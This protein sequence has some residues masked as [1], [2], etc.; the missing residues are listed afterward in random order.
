MTTTDPCGLH[1]MYVH[2][3]KTNVIQFY[4]TAIEEKTEGKI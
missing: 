3:G 1:Y 2:Q 4:I